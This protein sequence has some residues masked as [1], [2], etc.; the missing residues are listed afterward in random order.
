MC[1]RSNTEPYIDDET[2]S[3]KLD[4]YMLKAR[5]VSL[6]QKVITCNEPGS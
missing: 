6:L 2:S 4:E 1:L 3:F 5:S